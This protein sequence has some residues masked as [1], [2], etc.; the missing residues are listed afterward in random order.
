M[1]NTNPPDSVCPDY[2]WSCQRQLPKDRIDRFEIDDQ[3]EKFFEPKVTDDKKKHKPS[4]VKI[5]L[6]RLERPRPTVSQEEKEF[7]G[8]GV[9]MLQENFKFVLKSLA[10]KKTSFKETYKKFEKCLTGHVK[11]KDAFDMV[12]AL[13]D[14]REFLKDDYQ[15]ILQTLADDFKNVNL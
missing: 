3:K 9:L 10:K 5:E 12:R 6:V 13:S 1:I 4:E 11:M 7:I 8:P 14:Y 2:C 15:I